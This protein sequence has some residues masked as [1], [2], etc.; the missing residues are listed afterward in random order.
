M[1]VSHIIAHGIII[2]LVWAVEIKTESNQL[3]HPTTESTHW[4][5]IAQAVVES[6]VC[7]NLNVRGP[8]YLGLTSSL[9]RQDISS[10][11]IDYVEYLGPGLTWGRILSTFVK[12]MWSNDIKCKYMSMFPLK[13]LARKGLTLTLVSS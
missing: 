8:S 9:R 12:S 13:N 10:H 7:L 4:P 2:T 5:N 11:D 1:N 6:S 3:Y